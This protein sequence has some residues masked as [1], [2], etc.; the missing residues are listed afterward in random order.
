[1]AIK[2]TVTLPADNYEAIIA[3]IAK[4]VAANPDLTPRSLETITML[5]T[6]RR[7][8][9]LLDDTIPVGWL[10]SEALTPTVDEL[11]MA[12]IDPAYRGKHH[13][14]ALLRALLHPNKSYIFATYNPDIVAFTIAKHGFSKSSLFAVTKLSKGRFLRKRLNRKAVRSIHGRM[15]R[16]TAYYAVRKAMS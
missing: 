8:S 12:Y 4:S 2:V 6:Q 7:L 11:G 10:A 14:D 13:L 15:R 5:V 9:V 1:M 16:Q 3:S